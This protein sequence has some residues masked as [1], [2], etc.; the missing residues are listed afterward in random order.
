MTD[1][2]RAALGSLLFLLVAPGVV[3]GLLPWW[4]TGGWTAGHTWWPL[5]VLGGLLL[6]AGLAALLWAFGQFVVEGLGTPAPVAPTRHLVIGGLY[7]YVRNPMYVAIVVALLGQALLLGRPVLLAYA[8][9]AWALPAA[10]VRFYEEPTLLR[11]YGDE[12]R[13]YQRNVRAWI[14][15]RT[16]WDRSV[17]SGD[18]RS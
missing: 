13:E 17:R 5:R 8:L 16:P 6:A 7:R 4:L 9:C 15:R 2:I 3:V 18:D 11:T 14:P 1:R 12:Y 10:F